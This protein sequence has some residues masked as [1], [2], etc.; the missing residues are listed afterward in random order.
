[1]AAGAEHGADGTSC[2]EGASEDTLAGI[3]L[4]A[5]QPNQP[6][7]RRPQ[8]KARAGRVPWDAPSDA[9]LLQ[10]VAELGVGRWPEIAKRLEDLSDAN[11]PRHGKQCRERWF[12]HLD[13]ALTKDDFS[14]AE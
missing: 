11:P 8:A 13:P 3:P 5:F 1:M 4:T 6:V 9:L 7:R 14:P 12:N 2:T 10:L